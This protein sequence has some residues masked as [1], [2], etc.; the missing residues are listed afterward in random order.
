MP[1][2]LI[3]SFAV[4]TTM[5]FTNL[6]SLASLVS[7]IMISGLTFQAL[8]LRCTLMAARMTAFVCITAISGNVTHRRQPRWPII[9]LNSWSPS[10]ISLMRK[11]GL[12]CVFARSAISSSVCGTNSCSGG[13]RKR[14]VTG[15][16]S[17][18][19]YSCSKSSCWYGRILARASS[20][21]STVSEQIISR[22]AAMRLCEKNMC[23]VRQRPMPWPTS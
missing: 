15:W 16:P 3:S 11:I 5:S 23:S 6:N 2:M 7:G 1:A 22:N 12:C 20:R 18:A 17:S 9:G 14:I 21:S 10:I 19:S 4:W 8:C 13:S